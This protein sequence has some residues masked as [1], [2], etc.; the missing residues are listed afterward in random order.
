MCYLILLT[1]KSVYCDVVV[2]HPN[3]FSDLMT[4][5]CAHDLHFEEGEDR[6][7]CAVLAVAVDV[8]D[9]VVDAVVHGAVDVVVFDA[10]ADVVVDIVD[11]Y[12]HDYIC[13]VDTI[14]Y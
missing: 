4:S 12:L 11:Y 9:T 13:I 1:L 14:D 2:K 7:S 8:V 10:V 3:F 6:G 5:S